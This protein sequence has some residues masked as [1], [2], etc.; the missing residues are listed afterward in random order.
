MGYVNGICQWDMSMKISTNL[1][2]DVGL[3]KL[4]NDTRFH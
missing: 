3:R 2:N 4:Q 1:F